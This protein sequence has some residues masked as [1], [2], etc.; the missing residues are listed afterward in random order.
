LFSRDAKQP[1]IQKA[2][3][4]F[5]LGFIKFLGNMDKG[6]VLSLP[7]LSVLKDLNTKRMELVRHYMSIPLPLFLN[8]EHPPLEK[9]LGDLVEFEGFFSPLFNKTLD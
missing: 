4:D 5:E 8:A 1:W 7:I 6:I 9:V 3:A 2:N